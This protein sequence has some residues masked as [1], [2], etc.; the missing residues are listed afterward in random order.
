LG[1]DVRSRTG[2]A[3]PASPKPTFSA[4]VSQGSSRGSWNTRP[5]FGCGAVID[6]PSS[7]TVPALGRSSPEI[8]RSKVDFPQ[9]EPPTTA[10]ISPSDTLSVT[11]SSARTP[12]G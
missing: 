4:T 10:R 9:P 1:R 5:I 2:F 6:E 8:T 7:E 12:F 3:T 11:A